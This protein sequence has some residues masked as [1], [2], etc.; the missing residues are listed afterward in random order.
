MGRERG[1]VCVGSVEDNAGVFIIVFGF[2][3]FFFFSPCLGLILQP[4]P[5]PPPSTSAQMHS[6]TQKLLVVL[7]ERN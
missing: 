7:H 1:V 4:P 2:T 5:A 3:V 6:P